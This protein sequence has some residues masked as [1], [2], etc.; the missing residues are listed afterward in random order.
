MNRRVEDVVEEGR[1]I[2]LSPSHHP[3]NFI[4][5]G[6]F[7]MTNSPASFAFLGEWFDYALR[8]EL[9]NDSDNGILHYILAARLPDYD[10]SCDHEATDLKHR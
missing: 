10:H 9:M 2:Y 6:V 8:P 5:T 7:L 4:G 1:A 3:D